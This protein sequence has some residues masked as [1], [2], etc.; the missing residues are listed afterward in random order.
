MGSNSQ[1]TSRMGLTALTIMTASNMMGSGVFMLPSSLAQIGSISIWG[2]ALTFCGVLTLALIFAKINQLSPCQ[3]GVIA[4]VGLTFGPYIGLQTT[5]YYWLSTWIGNCALLISGVGYL[6]VFFPI[7]HHPLYAAGAC[8]TILWLFV[9]LGLQGARVVGYAQI[10]TGGCMLAVVLGIGVFGW[11][12]FDAQ[13]YM[14]SYNVTQQTPS[15]AILAAAAISLWGFLGIESASVSSAQV[16]NPKRN[17]PLATILGLTLAA[18]SY[19]SSSNVIMG[20]LPHPQLIDST[21]PFADTAHVLWGATAGKCISALAIIACLGAMPGWQILQ[22]EVPR[23][24]AEAGLFPRLFAATNRHGVAYK[25][26]ICTACLMTGVILL[27]ISPNLEQQFRTVIV[28]AI[29]ACLIPYAFAAISL[30]VTMV[31]KKLNRGRRFTLYSSLSL[32]GLAF[33]ATALLGAGTQPLFWGIILQMVTIPLYLL[34]VMRQQTPSQNLL[35]PCLMSDRCTGHRSFI[36][37]SADPD[38]VSKE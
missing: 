9:I 26:L 28:L 35:T 18:L 12:H 11:F 4:H 25:G 32:L 7:L 19:V 2:W 34:C 21:S 13:L 16:I 10:F 30:P 27:T 24:A 8:I 15:H 3:G 33:V 31:A 5:L 22:T 6:A 29:S 38:A 37:V 17:I 1:T 36:A 23:A 20:I 14:R